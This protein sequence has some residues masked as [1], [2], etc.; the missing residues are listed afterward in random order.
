MTKGSDTINDDLKGFLGTEGFKDILTRSVEV[1]ESGVGGVDSLA[2]FFID[3]NGVIDGAGACEPDW[4]A[5]HLA[6]SPVPGELVL[7]LIENGSEALHLD[8]EAGDEA[9]CPGWRELGIKSLVL[10]PIRREGVTVGCINVNSREV[11]SFNGGQLGLL[12]YVADRLC[13]SLDYDFELAT[14]QRLAKALS[15]EKSKSSSIQKK[16]QAS[17]KE[18]DD[19]VKEIQHRVNNNLQV[20]L[21]LVDLQTE[22]I[23]DE[24]LKE[25]FGETQNRIRSLALIYGHLYRS[26]SHSELSFTPYVQDL[27]NYLL[28]FYR[29]DPGRITFTTDIPSIKLDIEKAIT[30]GLILNELISNSIKHGFPDDM[31]GEIFVGL[32]ESDGVFTLRIGDGGKGLPEGL[33]FRKTKSLGLQL[34]VALSQQLGCPIVHEGGSGSVYSIDI[35]DDGKVFRK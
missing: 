10:V 32:E 8:L 26:E 15:T 33:N 2:I 16:V 17:L 1:I 20:I 6:K 13:S 23:E 24:L 4:F 14:C 7:R 27:G 35:P 30:L 25:V 5:G 22:K 29:V 28:M 9:L 21:S 31:G 11:R 18:K 3:E 34:V 19:F 12:N